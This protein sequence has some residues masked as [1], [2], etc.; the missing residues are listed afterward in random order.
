[1]NFESEEAGLEFGLLAL[2]EGFLDPWVLGRTVEPPWCG[3]TAA[4]SRIQHMMSLCPQLGLRRGGA[5]GGALR[6]PRVRAGLAT[7][8]SDAGR[9][10]EVQGTNCLER[11]QTSL[12]EGEVWSCEPRSEVG[13]G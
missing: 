8:Q 12:G 5:E 4:S 9:N 11:G 6:P 10:P 2:I 7:E 3:P 1:M 13:Q